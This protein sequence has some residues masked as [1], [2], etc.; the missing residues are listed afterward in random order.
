MKV[1]GV[2]RRGLEKRCQR[3][4]RHGVKEVARGVEEVEEGKKMTGHF[5]RDI[6][7]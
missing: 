3:K 2:S 6:L 1:K 5:S 4:R 7:K